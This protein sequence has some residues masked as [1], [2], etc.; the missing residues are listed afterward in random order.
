MNIEAVIRHIGQ[1]IKAL[2]LNK[3]DKSALDVSVHTKKLTVV[4]PALKQSISVETGIGFDKYIFVNASVKISETNFERYANFI[5]STEGTTL[6]ITNQARGVYA[7]KEMVIYI[8]Y[9]A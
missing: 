8:G 6:T 5:Y 9:E 3:A 7:G 1:D 4:C 2:R